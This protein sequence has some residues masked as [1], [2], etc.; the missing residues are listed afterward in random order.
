MILSRRQF[1]GV[2]TPPYKELKLTDGQFE[3]LKIKDQ[4]SK[5]RIRRLRG[6]DPAL[7]QFTGATQGRQESEMAVGIVFF[8]FGV[9][10]ES[11]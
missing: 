7:P 2:K 5:L 10:D 6:N 9:E 8:V 3:I 11:I 4:K 1:G